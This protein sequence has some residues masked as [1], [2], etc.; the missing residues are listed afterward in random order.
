[1]YIINV[2]N[3]EVKESHKN[4]EVPPLHTILLLGFIFAGWKWGDWRNWRKY[5]P[6]ILFFITGDLLYNFLT[7]NHPIWLFHTSFDK[8]VLPNHTFIT[9]A[10]EFISFPV[11][12]LIYLGHYPENKSKIKQLLY[13]FAWV[14]F[15]TAFE[16]IA[17]YTW[18]G[19]SHHNG[20]SL[21]STFLFYIVIF[22]Q[23]R[24]H[25]NRPLLAWAVSF[26]IITYLLIYF[27][28]PIAGM[29]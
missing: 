13:L 27:K 15:F 3:Y 22:V 1:M 19:I 10:V 25:Y 20:W 28:V 29:K 16:F 17:K 8:A 14:L 11:K 21:V 6:T 5:Y 7:Y 23:L 26:G 12:V 4:R 18:G 9:L 2:T 24:L